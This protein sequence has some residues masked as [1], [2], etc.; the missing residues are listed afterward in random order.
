MLVFLELVFLSWL[1]ELVSV[2]FS[3]YGTR[4]ATRWCRPELCAPL[5]CCGACAGDVHT[6]C[7][8]IM[9]RVF[10]SSSRT[11]F[12]CFYLCCFAR[13]CLH[14]SLQRCN[15]SEQFDDEGCRG[16]FQKVVATFRRRYY[17]NKQ[18]LLGTHVS[19][20]CGTVRP[21]VLCGSGDGSVRFWVW[22]IRHRIA[23]ASSFLAL[24]AA[25]TMTDT[26]FCTSKCC[27]ASQTFQSQ[28]M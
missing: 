26:I 5:Q 16:T 27:W 18:R 4:P 22:T 12:L 17:V 9:L 1:W 23:A 25:F 10:F 13:S 3:Q 19:I 2:G 20:N 8:T 14:G 15:V 21:H 28:A 24:F 6:L 11:F 7:S